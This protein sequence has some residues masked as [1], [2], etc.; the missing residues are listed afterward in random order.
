M[1]K[2]AKQFPSDEW[3]SPAGFKSDGSLATLKE[4]VDPT[5]DGFDLSDKIPTSELTK[6]LILQR[7]NLKK[8]F[9]MYV[10][11]EGEVDQNRAIAEIQNGTP[12]G[13]YLESFEKTYLSNL[14]KAARKQQED[15]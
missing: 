8:D 13:K 10:L 9:K 6:D 7:Y 3:A 12:L 2:N 15:K 5:K 4:V 11:G 1:S 14:V